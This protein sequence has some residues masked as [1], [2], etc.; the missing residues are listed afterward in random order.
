MK[1]KWIKTTIAEPFPVIFHGERANSP[2]AG[3]FYA[4]NS[5]WFDVPSNLAYRNRCAES[6]RALG[7]TVT[8]ELIE[9]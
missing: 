9:R 5:E 4:P 3:P 6:L 1:H 8:V 2:S 7:Y